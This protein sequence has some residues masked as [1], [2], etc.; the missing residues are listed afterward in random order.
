MIRKNVKSSQMKSVGYDTGNKVL[1]IEM[2]DGAIVQY[3]DVPKRE[4]E[5]LVKA[6]SIGKF[7]HRFIKG[8]YQYQQVI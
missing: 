8:K 5:N 3:Y 6:D 1:E 4:F 2:T 7:Y